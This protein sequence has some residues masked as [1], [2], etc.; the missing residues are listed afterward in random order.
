MCDTVKQHENVT[1]KLIN[2]MC[3]LVMDVPFNFLFLF[4]SSICIQDFV[5]YKIQFQ[6]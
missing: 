3:M 4:S 6:P 2:A 1:H 5:K